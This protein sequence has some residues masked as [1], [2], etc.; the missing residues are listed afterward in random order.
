MFHPCSFLLPHVRM[1]VYAQ[2]AFIPHGWT[3]LALFM[4]GLFSVS[5][6]LHQDSSANMCDE[7]MP[8]MDLR[9]SCSGKM[10]TAHL[11]YLR[12]LLSSSTLSLAPY[13]TFVSTSLTLMGSLPTP[14]PSPPPLSLFTS[15]A[16]LP[17]SEPSSIYHIVHFRFYDHVPCSTRSSISRQFT[18]LQH[19]CLQPITRRPYIKSFTGGTDISVENLQHGFHCV[20]MLEFDSE[21][22]RA[23]YLYEDEAHR[24]FG[25]EMLTGIVEEVMVLDFRRGQF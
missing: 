19:K 10:R 15:H 22:D 8:K 24:N 4:A 5:Q 14:E 9:K 17:S 6:L 7:R 21:K 1:I 11:D 23:F 25:V 18:S 13:S 3:R 20:F 16:A 2:Q 12:C